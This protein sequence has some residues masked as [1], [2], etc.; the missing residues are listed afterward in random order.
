MLL[1]CCIKRFYLPKRSGKLRVHMT[2]WPGTVSHY[3]AIVRPPVREALLQWNVMT[4]LNDLGIANCVCRCG[5]GGGSAAAV[6]LAGEPRHTGCTPSD[7]SAAG[8]HIG[9]EARQGKQ[10][11]IQ[12]EPLVCTCS[13]SILLSN[14]TSHRT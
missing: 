6:R 3:R 7:R 8:G 1:A 9:S 11:P 10:C 13:L 5:D 4:A 12:G 2:T 14:E